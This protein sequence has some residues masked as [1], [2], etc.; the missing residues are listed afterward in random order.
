ML[1]GDNF[2][3]TGQMHFSITVF[4]NETDRQTIGQYPQLKEDLVVANIMVFPTKYYAKSKFGYI[5]FLKILLVF[6]R[7]K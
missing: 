3:R 5:F 1:I 2:M 4:L 6:I 7:N